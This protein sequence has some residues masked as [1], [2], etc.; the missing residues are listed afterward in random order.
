MVVLTNLD[1][2]HARPLPIARVIAGL[3]GPA[4]LPARL[5]P[6]A[7]TEPSMAKNLRL[8]MDAA[9][10]GQDAHDLLTGNAAKR[11]TSELAVERRNTLLQVWPGGT[12][13]L[14]QR[15][16]SDDG[17]TASLY[18]VARRETLEPCA[19]RYGPRRQGCHLSPLARPGFR[20]RDTAMRSRHR[21][22]PAR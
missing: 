20:V 13:T 16:A 7:D 6:V 1:S 12:V 3:V 8:V 14:V 5:Q 15:S 10:A 18:R 9:A 4:L 2:G 11:W 17:Q 19:V 21:A 22:V